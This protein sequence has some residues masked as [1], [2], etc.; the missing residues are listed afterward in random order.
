MKAAHKEEIRAL[1]ASSAKQLGTGT[2][3]CN[4]YAE[5]IRV[6]DLSALTQRNWNTYTFRI[7]VKLHR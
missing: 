5:G 4:P 3:H 1:E 7:R 6:Q 2:G